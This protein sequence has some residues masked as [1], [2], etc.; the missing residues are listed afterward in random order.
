MADIKLLTKEVR[1]LIAA[2]E[3]VERPASV[4]KELV[5]N[6]VD[7][8]A[9]EIEIEIRRSGLDMIRVTDD[10]AGIAQEQV[11]LAFARH[12][13]SKVQ[14]A[15]D[16]EQIGTLGFRGEALAA[17][18][19]VSKVR[20]VTKQADAPNAT[21]YIIEAGEEVSLDDTGAPNGSSVYVSELFYNTPAR[22]KFL[23]KDVHEGNAVQTIAEQLALS[24]PE[25]TFRFV[26]DGRTVFSTPGDGDLYATVYSLLPREVAQDM[27]QV[28]PLDEQIRVTGYISAPKKARASRS[29]QFVFVNGRFIKS[30]S[31]SAAAEEACKNLVM[32]GKHPSFVLNIGLAPQ[33]V[34]VNVHPAKTEV[35]FK[36]E[37]AVFS[38]VYAAVKMAVTAYAEDFARQTQTPYAPQEAA[39]VAETAQ[40]TIQPQTLPPREETAP[41]RGFMAYVPETPAESRQVQLTLEQAAQVYETTRKGKIDIEYTDLVPVPQVPGAGGVDTDPG[42]VEGLRVVGELFDTYIVAQMGEAA[43][44]I[45]KHAAHE[46]LLFETLAG[47]DIGP[48]RQILLSPVVVSLSTEEKQ[49]L[50]DDAE[51]VQ[52]VGF[53]VEAFGENE[54]AVRETPTYLAHS[55]VADAVTQIADKLASK[56][57]DITTDQT[58]WLLHSVACR[59]AI[60]AGHKTSAQELVQLTTDILSQKIPKFCPHG[61]PIYFVM[62]KKELE[63]RFGRI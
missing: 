17:I 62:D 55:G 19:A 26:R 53:L 29:L 48:E 23:K 63:K 37:R 47:H 31:I 28:Q 36:N 52:R 2:G 11:P 54:V 6:A 46:R 1:E 34:D 39:P 22:M 24:H 15:D 38:A 59:A 41:L 8:G 49:A 45:D 50:L 20:L 16:L 42:N 9:G 61:R 18:S 10:G 40:D 27:V 5:E 12:A 30:R 7:A 60:K 56:S 3:V 35:R 33:D 44:F 32:Q 25:I 4:V 21:E 58:E 43:L 57:N 51:T 13:T 14:R